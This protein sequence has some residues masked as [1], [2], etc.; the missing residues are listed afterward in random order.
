MPSSRTAPEMPAG[1]ATAETAKAAAR[2][3]ASVHPC[4]APGHSKPPGL[5]GKSVTGKF[6]QVTPVSG[7]GRGGVAGVMCRLR[8]DRYATARA[9]PG[10]GQARATGYLLG[11]GTGVY[12]GGGW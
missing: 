1:V 11:Q 12:R 5:G 9:L 7:L 10:F 4:R 2:A 3:T 6:A 8:T